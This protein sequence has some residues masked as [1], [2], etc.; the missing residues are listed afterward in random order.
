MKIVLDDV[1]IKGEAHVKLFR[2]NKSTIGIAH[3][4]VQHDMTKH[5]KIDQHFVKEKLYIG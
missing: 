2:D 4:P 3:N 5:L 1:M